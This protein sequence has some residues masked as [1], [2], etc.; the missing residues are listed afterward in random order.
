MGRFGQSNASSPL[1]GCSLDLL[2]LV[3]SKT[4]TL[5]IIVNE[6]N[7]TYSFP[8]IFVTQ[9]INYNSVLTITNTIQSELFT[10]TVCYFGEAFVSRWLSIDQRSTLF[11]MFIKTETHLTKFKVLKVLTGKNL[12]EFTK[13][14]SYN[15][16]LIFYV[17]SLAKT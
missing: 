15:K 17:A 11:G 6:I 7:S 14:S 5:C 1:V 9:E 10:Q 2:M 4:T 8:C 16:T 13:V 3:L 12:P